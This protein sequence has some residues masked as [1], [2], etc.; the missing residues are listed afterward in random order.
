MGPRKRLR[1]PLRT[2]GRGGEKTGRV[3]SR[4]TAPEP[5]HLSAR[6]A[7]V[8]KKRDEWIAEARHLSRVR[9][10]LRTALDEAERQGFTLY[11][12]YNAEGGPNDQ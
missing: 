5:R 12:N 11:K 8:E 4:S 3:D 1:T 7:E 10:E 9:D 6:L 2:S